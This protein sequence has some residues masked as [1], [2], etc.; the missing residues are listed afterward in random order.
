MSMGKSPA[1]DESAGIPALGAGEIQVWKIPLVGQPGEESRLK[2]I[3]SPDERVQAGRFHFTHDQRRFVIRRAVLRQLLAASLE[4][5]PQE[6]RLEFGAYGKPFVSGQSDDEALRFSCSHSADWALI[7]VTRGLELGVDLEQH[8]TMTD[9]EDVAR[10]YFAETEI[11][12]LAALPPAFKTA[13][14][15]NCWTRKEAFIKALGLGLSFPLDR[16][17]VSLS[18]AKPAKLLMVKDDSAVLGKWS[19]ISLDVL[20]DYSAALVFEGKNTSIKRFAWNH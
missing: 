3:L 1:W 11:H 15:F 2:E 16:F 18:P 10:N 19:L 12:E 6:V 8:R 14:F 13:G 9:A 7:A 20:P 17:A 4:I 5:A